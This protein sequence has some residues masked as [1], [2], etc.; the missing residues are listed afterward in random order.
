MSAQGDASARGKA[1]SSWFRL[2]FYN[3]WLEVVQHSIWSSVAVAVVQRGSRNNCVPCSCRL[4]CWNKLLSPTPHPQQTHA[5]TH[6]CTHTLPFLPPPTNS[7]RSLWGICLWETLRSIWFT[8][9]IIISQHITHAD[10]TELNPPGHLGPPGPLQF[11]ALFLH[12]MDLGWCLSKTPA[13]SQPWITFQ[14]EL[15]QE[16]YHNSCAFISFAAYH[17]MNWVICVYQANPHF[18]DF[19]SPLSYWIQFKQLHMLLLRNICHIFLAI[20]LCRIILF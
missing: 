13:A 20:I 15:D 12:L 10:N 7:D 3:L 14:T 6:S 19:R 1:P 11:L 17:F 4:N 8:L 18:S 9:V 16:I 2:C 5:P